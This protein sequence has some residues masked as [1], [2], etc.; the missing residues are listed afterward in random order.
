MKIRNKK[1]SY[2]LKIK[3]DRIILKSRMEKNIECM[4]EENRNYIYL[5]GYENNIV[6]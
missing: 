6:L 5:N 1:T 4:Y 2:A 3:D